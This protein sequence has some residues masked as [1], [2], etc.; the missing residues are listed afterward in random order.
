MYGPPATHLLL[1]VQT[2][3][4]DEERCIT[5]PSVWPFGDKYK[6]DRD[7]SSHFLK[8]LYNASLNKSQTAELPPADRKRYSGVDL[9]A[10]QTERRAIENADGSGNDDNSG[11]KVVLIVVGCCVFLV[12]F[13]AIGLCLTSDAKVN[14]KPDPK[15]SR[16][17]ST[18]RKRN[19]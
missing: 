3:L 12:A 2:E 14:N 8:L 1:C 9:S 15:P 4:I 11:V 19:M 7:L 18:A 5:L 6:K 17:F 16:G 13:L 10:A